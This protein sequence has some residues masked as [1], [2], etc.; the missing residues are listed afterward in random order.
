MTFP[1]GFWN[2][3][4]I[5]HQDAAAV[6]DWAEAGMTLT[7]GPYYGSHPAEVRRMRSVLDACAAHAQA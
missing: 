6:S 4:S 5:E 7:V 1:I 3:R 2:Y